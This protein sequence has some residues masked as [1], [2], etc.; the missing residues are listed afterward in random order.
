MLPTFC[1]SGIALGPSTEWVVA[2]IKCQ[3]CQSVSQTEEFN[4]VFLRT[5]S[6]TM[7]SEFFA[8]GGQ[9]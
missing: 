7:D 2:K 9:V 5:K 6:Y 1:E 4:I 3:P 8:R